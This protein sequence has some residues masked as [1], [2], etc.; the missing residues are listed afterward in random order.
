MFAANIH[1]NRERVKI[2]AFG[3]DE[4]QYGRGHNYLTL[5]YQIEAGCT[6]L[7]FDDVRAD[8]ARRMTRDGYE[9][10]LKE[11]DIESSWGVMNAEC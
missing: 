1:R 4:I 6:R 8:E 10:V 11:N 2:S 5:A 9:P 3:V 7:L